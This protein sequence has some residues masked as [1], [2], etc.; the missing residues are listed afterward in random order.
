MNQLFQEIKNYHEWANYQDK[1]IVEWESTYE[2]WPK[3]IKLFEVFICNT[4]FGQWD[5]EQ[6]NEVLYIIARDNE[7]EMLAAMVS[8]NELLLLFLAEKALASE[9]ADAKWQLA[10]Q[11]PNCERCSEAERL[12]IRYVQDEAEYVNRRA[13]MALAAIGSG[14]TEKYCEIAWKRDCYGDLQ[15]YQRM[16]ALHALSVIE[17]KQLPKYIELAK[18]DGRKWLVKSLKGV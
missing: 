8:E 12:L 6:I 1:Q 17:S 15:E 4:D 9:E 2:E 3:I 18:Q 11:L 10:I 16:A 5:D 7:A 13:L 14:E